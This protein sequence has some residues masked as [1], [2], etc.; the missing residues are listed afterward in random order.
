MKRFDQIN[1]IPFIDI[2]LVLLAIVMTTATFISKGLI[3][4][5]LPQAESS[6]PAP[7]NVESKEIA[8]NDKGELYYDGDSVTFA[9]L[10]TRLA[11][12]PED[13]EFLLKIDKNARFE[14]FIKIIDLLKQRQLERVSI[15]TLAD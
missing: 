6:A 9:G 3:E 2:V 13:T 5:N 11:E 10:D 4:V 8:V 14:P 12:L 7:Q 1:M 15:E